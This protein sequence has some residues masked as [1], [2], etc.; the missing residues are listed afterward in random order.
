MK[1]MKEDFNPFKPYEGLSKH[2]ENEIELLIQRFT[3]LQVKYALHLLSFWK[4]RKN[5]FT[6]IGCW[7]E[8]I[9]SWLWFPV[10][11]IAKKDL[12]KLL[13]LVGR[14]VATIDCRMG[15]AQQQWRKVLLEREWKDVEKVHEF[16]TE[17]IN[18]HFYHKALGW[19][20]SIQAPLAEE[21][22][23]HYRSLLKKVS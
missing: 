22:E 7:T 4:E 14:K 6:S 13:R 8:D 2:F 9:L 15:N 18:Q 17:K 21:V 16:W 1:R 5:A 12:P 20:K 3:P 19:N 11:L 10:S 23:S